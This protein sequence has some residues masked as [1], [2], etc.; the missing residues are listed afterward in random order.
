MPNPV[1]YDNKYWWFNLDGNL[2]GPFDSE[3]DA[4]E[5]LEH[6]ALVHF[7][8]AKVARVENRK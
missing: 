5:G 2:K 7:P 1:F 6:Y 3:N 8:N 4:W